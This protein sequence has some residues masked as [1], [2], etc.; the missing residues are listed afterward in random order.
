MQKQTDLRNLLRYLEQKL[1]ELAQ[2]GN[3]WQIE[4]HG[5]GSS[6]QVRTS[7]ITQFQAEPMK[8]PEERRW[9]TAHQK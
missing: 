1:P 9:P 2:S 5:K 3:G 6:V 7:E 8:P 4:I